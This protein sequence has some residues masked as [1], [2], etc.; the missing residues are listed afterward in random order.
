MGSIVFIKILWLVFFI[1]YSRMLF[2][3]CLILYMSEGSSP[4]GD[5]L[6]TLTAQEKFLIF[7]LLISIGGLPPL[8]GFY[9]KLIILTGLL[10]N[11]KFFLLFRIIISSVLII[12]LYLSII[13][14]VLT[15]APLTRIHGEPLKLLQYPIFIIVIFIG[16][17]LIIINL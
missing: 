1:F 2:F 3:C 12:Y 4:E 6:I 13:L 7:L 14:R 5:P 8:L 10:V 16:S 9:I 15:L 11:I 17:P